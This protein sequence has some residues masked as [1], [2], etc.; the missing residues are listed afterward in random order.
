MPRPIPFS[1]SDLRAAVALCG[2]QMRPFQHNGSFAAGPAAL[3]PTAIAAGSLLTLGYAYTPPTGSTTP[4]Y[5]LPGC[6]WG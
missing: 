3:L 6:F 1:E 2:H 4:T 5:T